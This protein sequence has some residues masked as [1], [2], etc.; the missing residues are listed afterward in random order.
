MG[1]EGTQWCHPYLVLHVLLYLLKGQED[2]SRGSDNSSYDEALSPTSPGPLSVRPGHGERDLGNTITAPPTPELHGIN[3]VFLSSN[4]S[5]WSVEEVYE[6]IASLQGTGSLL[7]RTRP[8]FPLR[9]PQGHLMDLS[10]AG[11]VS[12][13]QH[14]GSLLVVLAAFPQC[15][16]LIPFWANAINYSVYFFFCFVFFNFW[17]NYFSLGFFFGGGIKISLLDVSEHTW[18]F[19]WST[20]EKAFV[21]LTFFKVGLPP[22]DVWL[23]V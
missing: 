15:I 18:L 17:I 5:R 2:S 6:F 14:R 11:L 22:L 1:R 21:W 19:Q 20:R 10:A 13:R 16:S 7:S 3:P 8:A 12:V 23:S 4:P 9:H